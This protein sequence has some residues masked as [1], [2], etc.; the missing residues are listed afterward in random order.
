MYYK[1]LY[2]LVCFLPRYANMHE[3]HSDADMLP[4]WRV[5][6]DLPWDNHTRGH[7]NDVRSAADQLGQHPERTASLPTLPVHLHGDT[8][9]D[10]TKSEMSW[11]RSLTK[12]PN[13]SRPTRRY[14]FDLEMALPNVHCERPLH[15]AQIVPRPTL[16]D[17]VSLLR[18]FRWLLRVISRS[19]HPEG[20]DAAWRK[21]KKLDTVE[22]NVPLEILLVLSGYVL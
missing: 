7:G 5:S 8:P 22:S 6:N 4:L 2:P 18:F 9:Y 21:L 10:D 11:F 20:E 16:S 12:S 15:P 14:T 3:A 13:S 17:R 19:R 1:D